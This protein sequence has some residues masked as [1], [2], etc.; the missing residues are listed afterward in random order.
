LHGVAATTV[1]LSS[2]SEASAG[3]GPGWLPQS[4]RMPRRIAS[5]IGCVR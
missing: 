5:V 3:R 2:A 4:S 1:V